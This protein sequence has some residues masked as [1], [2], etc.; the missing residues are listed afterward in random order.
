[1]LHPT[2]IQQDA[3][4]EPASTTK[5]P[6]K[7]NKRNAPVSVRMRMLV[8]WRGKTIQVPSP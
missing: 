1:L 4:K 2:T 8:E 3:V 7:Q 6:R 5:R